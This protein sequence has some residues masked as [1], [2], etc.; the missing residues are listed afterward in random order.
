[1][2][3]IQEQPLTGYRIRKMFEETAL[4]NYSSSPGTIYPALSR[5]EKNELVQKIAEN[6]NSKAYIQITEAG[7]LHLKNWFLKQIVIEDVSK[8]T[9]ELLLR[10]GFMESL[11]DKENR[12][13]FLKNFID[14]LK[15]YIVELENY[16]ALEGK[17]MPLHGKLAFQHGIDSYK[18]TLKWC[19]NSIT[20]LK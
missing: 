2:G 18:T 12:I 17:N 1:L 19:K 9:D 6:N 15:I 16:K 3:L 4:G 14:I 20:Q 5:L 11:I 7:I 13:N 8:R 10:F